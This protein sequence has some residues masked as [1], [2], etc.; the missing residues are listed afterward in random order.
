MAT[1]PVPLTAAQELMVMEAVRAHFH[2]QLVTE[3]WRLAS[4][5]RREAVTIAIE[6]AVDP[7][8]IAARMGLNRATV[9]GMYRQQRE[10][11]ATGG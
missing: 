4:Q 10:S 11:K 5:H 1:D 6:N 8:H 3:Q 7:R 9:T 2:L